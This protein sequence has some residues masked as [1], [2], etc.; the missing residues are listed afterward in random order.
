MA[1]DK[2]VAV[3]DS[4]PDRNAQGVPYTVHHWDDEM[5]LPVYEHELPATSA[6]PLAP[7]GANDPAA[8]I[9]AGLIGAGYSDADATQM[10][11]DAV[12]KAK[13]A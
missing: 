11:A 6:I 3:K 12:A 1:R 5:G 9:K 4:R 2:H 7:L 13:A 10:A 8:K